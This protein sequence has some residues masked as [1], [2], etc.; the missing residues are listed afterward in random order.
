MESNG[1]KIKVLSEQLYLRL[2]W[3]MIKQSFIC[4]NWVLMEYLLF[5]G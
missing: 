4:Q 3:K 5:K 2:R 1:I